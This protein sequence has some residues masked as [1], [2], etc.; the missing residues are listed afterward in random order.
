MINEYP[1]YLPVRR[2]LI[3]V[4]DKTGVVELAHALSSQNIQIL[5]T[6]GTAALLREAG[7][8]LQEVSE[9]T[10][11]P[12]IMSGRLKTLHPKIHGGLLARRNLDAEVMSQHEILPIDLLVV[13]LYPFIETIQEKNCRLEQAVEQID[14]GGPTMLRAAA[15][16]Y[17]YVAAVTESQDYAMLLA[18][19][20]AHHQQLSLATRFKL[21]KK[22]FAHTA[23]YEAAIANYLHRFHDEEEKE[24]KEDLPSILTMQFSK[25]Y[26]LRYGEN[27]H[28]KAAL[29]V[30]KKNGSQDGGVA[31]ALQHQGKPLSFNNMAD[32]DA[33]LECI[34]HFNEMEQHAC[35]IVKH[36]NPCGVAVDK[37][38]LPAYQKAFA[39]D[40]TSAFGGIIAFNQT[41]QANTARQIL[42]KQFVEVLI[43][44]EVTEEALMLL[45]DKP[46]I[47]VLSC[48][49]WQGLTP[50]WDFVPI[51]G[52]LLV[53]EKDIALL[54]PQQL[55]VV[56][57]RV[58]T[59]QELRDL[60]FAW[61]VVKCVKSN[62]IVYAKNG[63]TIGIG[64]GQMSRVFSAI[65][66]NK[67]AFDAGLETQ[68]AVMASD[69]FFPFSDAI[70]AAAKAQIA[71]IIQ[72]G[73]SIRDKEVIQA[74][75]EAGIAMVLTGV[76][77]FK[78]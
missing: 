15:K 36:A 18:E 37:E 38:Q 21:A 3:S 14:I 65:I 17:L 72:P 49:Q 48:G 26:D 19:L 32:A 10:G 33:A 54:T 46:N 13:N 42:D 35:V 53:Q 16:N 50:G 43:A 5:S 68:G 60:L 64:A 30:N 63:S 45:K 2:A 9:Y 57:R 69:A 8:S 51:E 6:G 78:H 7:I 24:N 40:S 4:S 39:A 34:K 22:V 56:T 74:A 47:R 76:R 27:P 23:S 75:D 77:H 28:Q 71:A 11:F 12:E 29:Y 59:D 52:G 44:P 61:K 20:K 1:D 66:A 55:Q 25:K 31:N 62:A 70:E 58:P 67:K 41:L 73:G